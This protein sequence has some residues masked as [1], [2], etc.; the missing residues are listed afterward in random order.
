M[1]ISLTGKEFRHTS[2]ISNYSLLISIIAVA[3]LI[4][5]VDAASWSGAVNTD[6]DSW[7][8]YRESSNLSFSCEQSVKGQISAVDF[9]GRSLPPFHSY[10]KD[11]EMNQVR[12][13][14]RTAAQEGSF[15]S[16]EMFNLKSSI[17][18]SV[19][20]TWEKPAGSNLWKVDYYE[21]W[22][23]DMHYSKSMSY[24]GLGINDRQFVG[25]NWDFIGSGILY[26]KEFSKEQTLNMS[27]K[28]LNATVLAT[29]QAIELA[30]IKATRDTEYKLEEHS[31]GIADFK[32][33]QVAANGEVLNAGDERFV[34]AYD[35][36]KNI[37]MASKNVQ[38]EKN[39]EWLPCCYGGWKDMRYYDQKGFGANARSVFDCTCPSYLI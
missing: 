1:T 8:I 37:Y 10:Y 16:Q 22:P 35:I 19:N 3:A 4:V 9:R 39:D 23:V 14:E 34:G 33:R 25:N 20:A 7:Y 28:R 26:S 30:E 18:N 2:A 11:V 38:F 21:K 27:L 6:S 29:D 15:S 32:Y 31:T 36:S 5:A 17:N 13:K 12:I 24:S